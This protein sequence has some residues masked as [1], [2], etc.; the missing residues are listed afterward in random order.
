MTLEDLRT[1]KSC[2]LVNELPIDEESKISTI[3]GFDSPESLT[4]CSGLNGG[5]LTALSREADLA[6]RYSFRSIAAFSAKTLFDE[7]VPYMREHDDNGVLT[8]FMNLHFLAEARR[9]LSGEVNVVTTDFSPREEVF[10][11][12]YQLWTLGAIYD[13]ELLQALETFDFWLMEELQEHTH[14]TVERSYS[15]THKWM[16]LEARVE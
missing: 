12:D 8:I 15:S 2:S 10:Y 9:Q 6:N 11:S 14:P 7:H 13:G 5:T 1:L 4:N 3:L 16:K